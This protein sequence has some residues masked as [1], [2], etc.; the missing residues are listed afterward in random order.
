MSAA[1][2]LEGLTPILNVSDVAASRDWFVKLGW[3]R[4][5]AWNDGG[6][7]PDGGDE[8]EHGPATFAAV[9]S[10]DFEIFMCLD[11]QG[12]RAT[13]SSDSDGAA[14]VWMSWWLPSSAQV[15]R[16]HQ[17]AQESGMTILQPPVDEP[18]GVHEFHL[19]HPDGHTF[20][21]GAACR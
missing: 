2:K 10:G 4:G 16:V 11:G 15:D 19:R 1:L 21:I 17:L 12:G 7:I 8:N 5:F 13:P 18:W 9:C 20:R 14:G 6:D 3:Q